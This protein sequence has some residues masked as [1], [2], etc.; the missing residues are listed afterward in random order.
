MNQCP[1][2]ASHPLLSIVIPVY[3]YAHTLERAVNSVISQG[4]EEVEVIL[5]DDGSTDDSPQ[6]CRQLASQHNNIRF[7][8]QSNGGAASARNHG[9]RL[10]TGDYLL[11][12]DADDE[13]CPG[14]LALLVE[15]IAHKAPDVLPDAVIG[16]HVAREA[17]GTEKTY[18]P[19]N[20]P[21]A[22]A[23]RIKAYLLDKKIRIS[24]GAILIHRRL[25]ERGVFP[26]NYRNG[27]D[28]PVFAQ[29]LCADRVIALR[30]PLVTVNK[31]SDSLRHQSP[32]NLARSMELVD[33]I[34][35]EKRL[36][37]E[38]LCWRNR[39]CALRALSLMRNLYL[40][41]QHREAVNMYR[42]ALRH[43]P[44]VLF[45]WA[46]TRKM[47]KALLS[48][49]ASLP[50]SL[51]A[52]LRPHARWPETDANT[53]TRAWEQWGGSVIL[54]PRIIA[55]LS[56]I[57]GVRPVYRA[58]YQQGK[59][60]AVVPTWGDYLAG[61]RKYLESIGKKNQLDTGDNEYCFPL[62]PQARVRLPFRARFLPAAQA[63]Q[64][65]NAREESAFEVALARSHVE[66]ENK[67]ARKFK[68]NQKRALR[69]FEEAG[70]EVCAIKDL[71]SDEIA[72]AYMELFELRWGFETPGKKYLPVVVE[73]LREYLT[74]SALRLQGRLIAIQLVLMVETPHG[75]SAAYI[76]G[77]YDPACKEHSPGSILCYLNTEAAE[78]FALA[79]QKPLRYHFGKMD[80]EYKKMWCYTE[81]SYRV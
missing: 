77:G 2:S 66:G 55:I 47:L 5:V 29:A 6:L 9:I 75:I 15:Q 11:F 10:A 79:R 8:S 76:N 43:Y 69:L 32:H 22:P 30:Q 31:H 41:G 18:A 21:A 48:L 65:S 34:F 54:H 4:R 26:E 59:L 45:K 61:D 60:V 81:K 16:G 40:A 73:R 52:S 28:L 67:L 39:Y 42:L 53:Y 80:A 24:N 51:S 3:N 78:Q 1:M 13:L 49:L 46:Y 70:G 44:P 74:G 35:N 68:Y 19:G 63:A 71:S 33:D 12:L 17:N 62:D 36:P 7:V 56:D 14:A 23:D 37:K 38:A 20:I 58:C 57:A 64:I 72:R 25:F 27:E 50:A